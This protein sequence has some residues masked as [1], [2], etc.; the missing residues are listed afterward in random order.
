MEGRLEI[1]WQIDHSEGEMH[2]HLKK[3]EHE[4]AEITGKNINTEPRI[5][6]QN[7][8]NPRCHYNIEEARQTIGDA[9]DQALELKAILN[10]NNDKSFAQDV[11][12]KLIRTLTQI[13]QDLNGTRN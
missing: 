12:C 13:K 2:S 11:T 9:V 10:D 4:L 5:G 6:I 8:E 7:F 3:M 1:D